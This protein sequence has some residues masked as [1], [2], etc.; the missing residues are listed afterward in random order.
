VTALVAAT[1]RRLVVPAPD[2]GWLTLFS[3]DEG[4]EHVE[5]LV[6]AWRMQSAASLVACQLPAFGRA[7]AK[8][9]FHPERVAR[10]GQVGIHV[11]EDLRPTW[12]Q[13]RQVLDLS[14]PSVRVRWEELRLGGP[15]D[16]GY[17]VVELVEVAP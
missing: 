12:R 7:F 17:L 8:V 4:P 13:V 5:L 14:S 9:A 3:G 11:A 6:D 10:V 16:P 2:A 1:E 15:V